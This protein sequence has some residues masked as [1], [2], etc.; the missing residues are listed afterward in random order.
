MIC[1]KAR[2]ASSRAFDTRLQLQVQ[3]PKSPKW[4]QAWLRSHVVVSPATVKAVEPALLGAVLW[5]TLGEVSRM[6]TQETSPRK[7]WKGSLGFIACRGR[8]WVYHIVCH[9][10]FAINFQWLLR[11]KKSWSEMMCQWV[12]N[13]GHFCLQ[14]AATW[15]SEPFGRRQRW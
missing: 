6:A 3:Q 4:R 13:F 15:P 1:L 2:C 8:A 5:G 12:K 9:R 14:S 11:A 10:I 7:V